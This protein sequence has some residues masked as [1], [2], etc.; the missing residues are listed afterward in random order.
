MQSKSESK[1][2]NS[3]SKVYSE[4]SRQQFNKYKLK[5]PKLKES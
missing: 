1:G 3:L 5:F 4:F 2:K